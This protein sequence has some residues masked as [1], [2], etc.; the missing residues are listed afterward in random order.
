[1]IMEGP[2][3]KTPTN[4]EPEECAWCKGTGK[5][6]RDGEQCQICKGRGAVL[7]ITVDGEGQPAK[8]TKRTKDESK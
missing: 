7:T 6:G 5:K 3:S 2:M 8:K 1:M 4:Y